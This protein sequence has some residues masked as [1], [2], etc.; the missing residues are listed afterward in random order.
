[1]CPEYETVSNE[2]WEV[3]M[4]YRRERQHWCTR[5]LSASF[6]TWNVQNGKLRKRVEDGRDVHSVQDTNLQW[7]TSSSFCFCKTGTGPPQSI[8]SS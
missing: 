4:L 8:E 5:I 3:C 7:T 6:I 2:L 1:M